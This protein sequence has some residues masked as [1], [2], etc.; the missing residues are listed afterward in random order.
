MTASAMDVSAVDF[1][2]GINVPF[3]KIG[4]GDSNNVILLDKVA[5]IEAMNVVIS[6]GMVDFHQVEKIYQ[7]FKKSR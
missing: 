7:L 5:K 6:T 3:L 1:L 2:A 4:S